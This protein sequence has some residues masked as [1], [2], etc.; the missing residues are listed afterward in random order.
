MLPY[1]EKKETETGAMAGA[2]KLSITLPRDLAEMVRERV[3]AGDYASNSEV[4]RAALRLWQEREHLKARKL[5]WLRTKIDRSL[6]D[7]RPALEADDVFAELETRYGE[8]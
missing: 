3:R 5:E 7:S 2:E 8:E 4:V 1:E 6:D